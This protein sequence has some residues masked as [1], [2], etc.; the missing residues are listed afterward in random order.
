MA[1]S[2]IERWLEAIGFEDEGFHS[3]SLGGK[4]TDGHAHHLNVGMAGSSRWHDRLF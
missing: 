1:L 4:H 2:F 3:D